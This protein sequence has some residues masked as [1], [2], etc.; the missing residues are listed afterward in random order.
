MYVNNHS[1]PVPPK[2]VL[3]RCHQVLV[4]DPA[5]CMWQMK[6]W[7]REQNLS[8]I[9]S[10]I[11]ETADASAVFDEVAA[12]YFIDGKDATAFTLKFK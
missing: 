12:F 3:D 4:G 2:E 7:C 1:I 8:L 10:E 5:F 11:V 6:R 9:Y